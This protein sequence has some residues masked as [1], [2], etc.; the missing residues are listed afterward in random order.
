[1]LAAIKMLL[2]GGEVSAA[3]PAE[4]AISDLPAPAWRLHPRGGCG[5]LGGMAYQIVLVPDVADVVAAGAQLQ[6]AQAAACDGRLKAVRQRVLAGSEAAAW[7]EARGRLRDTGE[8]AAA[9]DAAA[10]AAAAA[11][12]E[13]VRRGDDSSAAEAAERDAQE[14][15]TRLRRRAEALEALV[16]ERAAALAAALAAARQAEGKRVAALAAEQ[17][18]QVEAELVAAG[19]LAMKH[20]ALR[21]LLVDLQH[22]P[23]HD[24]LPAE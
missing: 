7:R 16:A 22:A 4:D 14:G 10:A 1:M 15:A 3:A 9:L 8:R 5:C 6:T 17:L 19:Q 20:L 18:C 21:A 12:T 13:A 24:E 23:A 2:G 11:A